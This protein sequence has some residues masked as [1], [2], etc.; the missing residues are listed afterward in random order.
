M[1]KATYAVHLL[2]YQYENYEHDGNK[3]RYGTDRGKL[4]CQ[5]MASGALSLTPSRS[6]K[7]PFRRLFDTIIRFARPMRSFFG[8]PSTRTR[9]L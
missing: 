5:D 2:L 9:R 7:I 1:S 4:L 6:S 8:G 3:N